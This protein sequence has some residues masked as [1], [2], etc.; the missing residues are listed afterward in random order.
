MDEGLRC[1]SH[2]R[3]HLKTTPICKVQDERTYVDLEVLNIVEGIR[4]PPEFG[5]EL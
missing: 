5:S 1:A 3:D 4:R 2:G